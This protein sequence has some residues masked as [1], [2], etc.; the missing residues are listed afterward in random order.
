MKRLPMIVVLLLI[1]LAAVNAQAQITI[2]QNQ[3]NMNI[4]AQ[5]AASSASQFPPAQIDWPTF[6][7][8]SGGGHLWDFSSITFDFGAHIST[9]VAT[10]AVPRNELFP[11]ATKAWEYFG[12][13]SWTLFSTPTNQLLTHGSVSTYGVN[14][15]DT[16][17]TIYEEPSVQLQFPITGGSSWVSK[18]QFTW[19]TNDSLGNLL[20]TNTVRDST[21]WVCDAWGSIKFKSKQAE[22]IRAKG[23]HYVITTFTSAGQNPVV[24]TNLFEWVQ[25]LTPTY[26]SGISMTRTEIIVPGLGT[27]HTIET[28]TCGAD[29]NLVSGATDV[30][31]N[32]EPIVPE[33][34]TLE[35]NVPNPF[36]PT[37]RI[38]YALA[39][40]A[41]VEFRI[42]NILGQTVVDRS[43]GL[44]SPGT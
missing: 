32:F 9:V 15:K 23:M 18:F 20:Y 40:A 2:N 4:G 24:D 36:N 7:E 1:C 6:W 31:E 35:Q 26:P 37:T 12:L 8:G 3:Y 16:L 43:F 38:R 10:S 33:M 25:F 14:Q 27:L 39:E 11:Q 5:A 41:E 22:V 13:N 29:Y 19:E 42:M 21:R 28:I 44:R 30:T 34:F 17:L